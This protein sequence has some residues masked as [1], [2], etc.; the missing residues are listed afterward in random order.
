M[1][2]GG[3]IK[4]G[5]VK[6]CPLWTFRWQGLKHVDVITESRAGFKGLSIKLYGKTAKYNVSKKSF[7]NNDILNLC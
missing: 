6:H 5:F 3:R 2:S 1:K 7:D 4:T